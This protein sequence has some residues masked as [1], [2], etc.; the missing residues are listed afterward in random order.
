M[1]YQ[2]PKG[3]TDILPGESEKWQFIEATAR[4]VFQQ[5]CFREMRTPIF[6]HY[7][8]VARNVGESTDIVTKEMY[9]FY[10][11]GN[12][13]VTLR[14]EG[15][16]PLVRSYVEHKLYGP[17]YAHPFKAYYI[18]P[19][20]RYERPQAGRLRQFH[21]IG[22]EVIDSSSPATDVET[23][24]MALDFFKR[25]GINQIKLVINSLGDRTSRAL[26]RQTLIEY[27]TTFKDQLSE[28]SKRRLKQ[29]PLRVLDSKE[30]QDQAII[31]NAPSILASLDEKGAT[32]FEEVQQL[33]AT[34]KIPFVIDHRMVRGLDYY[35]H[36]V[37]EIMSDAP[38]F[39]G[40][41][42]TICAGG[43]YD[44]LVSE[45]SGPETMD[46]GFG[47]AMGIERVLLAMESVGQPIPTKGNI[48]VYIIC[49]EHVADQAALLIA[50]EARQVGLITECDLTY[51]KLK[52]QLRTANRLN[53][54]VVAILGE[55]EIKQQRVILKNMD[56]GIETS[57]LFDQIGDYF[58]KLRAEIKEQVE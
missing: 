1:H 25:L 27:L 39:S 36:T 7:E 49:L 14:P 19:M 54:Q 23:M 40:T 56:S 33:L 51:R 21:Q 8:V 55:E 47:F 16:A 35:N 12:R 57:V 2:K 18:G 38:T 20:F 34:L 41:L 44:G 4:K 6:E 13:H 53:A 15:T 10:D 26:Y 37:F 50:Q 29:N 5:Y 52:N 48:A 46:T 28:D 31:K 11:K 58:V 45:F 43:R 17:E 3:T 22:A 42:T 30:E 9:D 32:F 24:A